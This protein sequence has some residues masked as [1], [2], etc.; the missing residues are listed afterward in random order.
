[1]DYIE[2]LHITK[3]FYG[4]K[5]LDDVSLSFHKGEVHAVVGENGA[6]KSTIM[7]IL[8]GLYFADSG[9]V[10]ID[11]TRRHINSVT[12]ALKNGVSV[13]YQEL[14]LMPDL[15]VAEN[16]YLHDLPARGVLLDKRSMNKK[17]Q[18]L[19][20]DMQVDI[21]ATDPI[22]L[23]SVSQQ[24]M[25]EIAKA[26]SHDSDIVIMD[27][28]TAAL[29][30]KE[31][32]ALYN[33]VRSLKE[34]GK[35]V[36]YISHRLK[37]IF[38]ISDRVSVLRDGRYIAT[39]ESQEITQDKLVA[40]MVGREISQFFTTA[41]HPYGETILEVRNLSKEGM[42][43]GISFELHKGE[44]LGVA[45][46]MGCFRE[47]IVKS[48]Y[49]LVRLDGGEI[50]LDGKT[51]FDAK[52]NINSLSTPLKAI[53]HGIG[54][55]TEDRK[56][57]GVFALMTVREN[58][59]VSILRKLSKLGII[60]ASAE[61][62]LLEHYTEKMDM[63]YSR[64]YQRINSLS[65]G[66]QQKFLLARTLATDCRVLIMLEP[67]RGIDVGAKAEIYALLEDLAKNGMAIIIV[68]SELPEI[69]GNCHR[70][71]VIFQG[72]LTG[73]IPKKEFDE[74]IIMQCATGNK[75]TI[76]GAI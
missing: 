75:T 17:A 74:T 21:K 48:L 49:G 66:N 26:L 63:K 27:E 60:R 71:L 32:E 8:G 34:K 37:E 50:I 2:L 7:K 33:I 65:G 73:D 70:T 29:N 55:V 19:L 68:S 56:N 36:I 69:M 30:V 9:E 22:G 40:M 45:G 38:D 52:G 18:A 24:Q 47:E 46:L 16:I 42:F 43:S 64:Y 57:S 31:V 11:G 44:I 13:V 14:D 25:V 54:Y 20:D 1:L 23:L 62:E 59:T 53:R 41:E 3:T 61:Q 5:A 35:T 58:I 67:T 6:G 51:V 39:R 10:H 12:D 4:V 72:K 28:P 76:W 15:T